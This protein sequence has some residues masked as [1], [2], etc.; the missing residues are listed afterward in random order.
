VY[1]D[2]Q[3][4]FISNW[5]NSARTAEISVYDIS[6]R[7][8]YDYPFNAGMEIPFGNNPAGVYIVEIN[9]DGEG[10]NYFKVLKP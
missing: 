4:L 8:I 5:P 10:R 7:K 9:L 2:N 3:T 1:C 6:G